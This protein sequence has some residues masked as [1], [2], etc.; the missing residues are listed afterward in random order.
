MKRYVDGFLF[1]PDF[2]HLVLIKKARP[3]WQAGRWNAVG[4]HVEDEENAADAMEREFR[5]E[6][7]LTVLNWTHFATLSDRNESTWKVDM[8]AACSPEFSSVTTQTDE[9]IRVWRT[10]RVFE[11]TE[12]MIGNIPWLTMMAKM[13]LSGV[14]NCHYFRILEDM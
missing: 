4:G 14:E 5:E 10:Q 2:E 13:V 1:S 3:N 7:G 8:F 9:E 6:T 12:P 11:C